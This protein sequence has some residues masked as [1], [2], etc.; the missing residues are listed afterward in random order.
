MRIV[1]V[2]VLLAALLLAGLLAWRR[3][4]PRPLFKLTLREGSRAGVEFVIRTPTA[5]IGSADGQTVVVSHPKVSQRH[6]LLELADGKVRL[7]DTSRY[8]TRV[9]GEAAKEAE[10][11][12]GDLIRLGDSVDLI[13]TR[14]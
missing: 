2:V 8:G 9:N 4:R 10:L 3:L 5:S 12:S 11:H 7:R 13:F 1:V 14:L 6:A